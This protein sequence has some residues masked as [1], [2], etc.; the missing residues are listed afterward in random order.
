MLATLGHL[1]DDRDQINRIQRIQT[2]SAPWMSLPVKFNSVEAEVSLPSAP[3]PE[4]KKKPLTVV[5]APPTGHV[6]HAP[7]VL[8]ASTHTVDYTCGHCGAVLMHAEEG[9]VYGLL[10]RCASCGS[11]NATSD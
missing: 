8:V 7:P 11:Y 3:M 9:Q 1:I 4:H 6:L 2:E 10:I 5:S